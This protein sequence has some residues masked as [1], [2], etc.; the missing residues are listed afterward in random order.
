MAIEKNR[1]KNPRRILALKF[2][3]IGD[4]VLTTSPIKTLKKI[5]PSSKIDLLTLSD[6]VPL[7]EGVDFI[8]NIL[9]FN[10]D[11]GIFQLLK[12]GKWINKSNYDLV[13]DFHNSL[14]SK[15]IRAYLKDIPF[16]TLK[17]PRWK[18]F[19]LFRL[20]KNRFQ[21]DFNQ[22]QLLHNPIRELS[23]NKPYPST[24]LYI[25]NEEKK[26]AIELLIKNDING[27]Y[28]AVVPG[29]AWPQKTWNANEYHRLFKKIKNS[30]DYDF[31]ILGGKNDNIC[32]DLT[33]MDFQYLNLQGET[34]IRETMAIIAN[35][36]L[37]IGA[38]T[39]FVHAG[40]ALG[41][42]VVMILGPTSRESGAG[43]NRSSSVTIE[44]KNVWCRP[45]SQNGKRK[46]YREEQYCMTANTA[47]IVYEEMKGLLN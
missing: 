8:D 13:I 1:I 31:V 6:F 30:K 27:N 21:K 15:I 23:N 45:C 16:R 14:R 25:S 22:R 44:N 39:G 19:L 43:T 26:E 37:V 46:C 24:E 20:R 40:E 4:I 33:K 28:I 5:F 29:A 41:K 34:N 42:N 7:V 3:S 17:K 12:T 2:S 38:D 9:Y 10:R 18:R 35:S 47:D 32:R 11:A 36:E